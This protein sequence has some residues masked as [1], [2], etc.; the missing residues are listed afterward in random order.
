MSHT[1]TDLNELFTDYC[2]SPFPRFGGIT[3]PFD[4]TDLLADVQIDMADEDGYI[5]G[6]VQTY[7]A[8]QHLTIKEI[9]IDNTIDSRL[10]YINAKTENSL[11]VIA[12]FIEYRAKMLQLTNVLAEVS[13]VK[14]TYFSREK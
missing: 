12:G 14:I 1:V 6:L 10:S 11:E 3:I 13:G 7:L 8:N 4:L 9:R 2:K 5:A